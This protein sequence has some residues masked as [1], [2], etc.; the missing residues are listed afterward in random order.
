[1]NASNTALAR[2]LLVHWLNACRVAIDVDDE[3]QRY[4]FA[5]YT[6]IARSL[7]CSF[8]AC[9]RSREAINAQM[10]MKFN[11]I[12]LQYGKEVEKM[13]LLFKEFAEAPPL[14]KNHPPGENILRRN[15]CSFV[16]WLTFVCIFFV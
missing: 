10:M 7:H 9:L 5:V 14:H 2:S 8:I 12:L 3:I 11:D 6:P 15:H 1:M 4:S 13:D 16:F